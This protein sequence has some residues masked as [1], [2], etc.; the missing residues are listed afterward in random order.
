MDKANLKVN[1][2]DYITD[3]N[4]SLNRGASFH[5]NSQKNSIN[6]LPQVSKVS[7]NIDTAWGLVCGKDFSYGVGSVYLKLDHK[8]AVNEVI[9]IRNKLANSRQ[10][11]S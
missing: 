7:K 11:E 1:S 9:K 8:E 6:Q 3:T 5:V 2:M 4:N 10:R